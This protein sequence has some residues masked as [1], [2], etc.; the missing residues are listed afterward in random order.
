MQ[1][2]LSP[3]TPTVSR[4]RERPD[5]V[6]HAN[7]PTRPGAPSRR[8][9]DGEYLVARGSLLTHCEAAVVSSGPAASPSG[10]ASASS[11]AMVCRAD[12]FV[13]LKQSKTPLPLLSPNRVGTNERANKGHAT[14]RADGATV[15]GHTTR[16]PAPSCGQQYVD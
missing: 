3:P 10:A 13:T 9:V 12:T 6:R 14:A 7:E 8:L 1:A 11:E 16:G 2:F 15:D 4:A 5:L